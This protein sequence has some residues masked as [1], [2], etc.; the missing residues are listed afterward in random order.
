MP[1]DFEQ[2]ENFNG[3]IRW[4]ALICSFALG[5]YL[6][7]V[8]I[9]HN[10]DLSDWRVYGALCLAFVPVIVATLMMNWE[11]HKKFIICTILVF[12]SAPHVWF[13]ALISECSTGNCI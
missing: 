13:A 9:A 12:I 8:P 10:T 2:A 7:L 11:I 6:I 3:P 5:P 4:I 1:G